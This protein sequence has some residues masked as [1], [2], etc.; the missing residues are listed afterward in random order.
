MDGSHLCSS[1]IEC[2]VENV[3]W[4]LEDDLARV[5]GDGPAHAVSGVARR[6]A[7]ALR[8]F[9]GSRRAEQAGAKSP[10]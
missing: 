10:E 3:R 6:V 5:V 7:Q 2:L 9:V 4:D 1:I 8:D